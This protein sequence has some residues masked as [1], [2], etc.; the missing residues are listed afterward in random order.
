ML[1]DQV[2]DVH[3]DGLTIL[4]HTPCANPGMIDRDRCAHHHR[5]HRI[6]T[7]PGE[8]DP[9]QVVSDEVGTRPGCESSDVVSPQHLRHQ[10]SPGPALGAPS[11]AVQSRCPVRRRDD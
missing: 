1:P 7:G 8:L 2:P 10:L 9:V 3:A 11:S 5:S 4:D 6:M